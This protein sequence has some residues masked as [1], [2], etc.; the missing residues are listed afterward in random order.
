ML[1]TLDARGFLRE[2]PQRGK[3]GRDGGRALLE[4]SGLTN[5]QMQFRVQAVS[6]V[7]P[8][9]LMAVPLLLLGHGHLMVGWLCGVSLVLFLCAPWAETMGVCPYI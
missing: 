9:H 2:E 4:K 6:S 5:V 7:Y 3:G 8:G 1:T